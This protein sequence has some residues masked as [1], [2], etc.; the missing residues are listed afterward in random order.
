MSGSFLIVS[1]TLVICRSSFSVP[2]VMVIC[3]RGLPPT[4]AS[5]AGGIKKL[6]LSTNNFVVLP[7][8]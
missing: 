2:K 8:K 3:R 1:D 7:W 5:N 4:L 6:R